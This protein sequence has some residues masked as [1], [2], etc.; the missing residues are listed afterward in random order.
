MGDI[1][2][3]EKQYKEAIQYYK[4]S[5]H[6]AI[7]KDQYIYNK[8]IEIYFQQNVLNDRAKLSSSGTYFIPSS[9]NAARRAHR[10]DSEEEDQDNDEQEDDAND[11][12]GEDGQRK[13]E[14]SVGGEK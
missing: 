1:Y 2:A 10:S 3:K 9:S 6:S 12:E 5:L 4:A 7:I 13:E 11:D 14:S 8:L